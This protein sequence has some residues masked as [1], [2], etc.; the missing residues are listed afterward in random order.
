[1]CTLFQERIV[2]IVMLCISLTLYCMCYCVF[3]ILIHNISM[4]TAGQ[5]CDI[6]S[7]DTN[8]LLNAFAQSFFSGFKHNNKV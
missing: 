7:I 6:L 2:D 4:N 1:M 8:K 5:G 3:C